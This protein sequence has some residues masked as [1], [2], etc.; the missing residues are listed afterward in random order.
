M[1]RLTDATRTQRRE[2]IAAAAMR[3]FAR[4]GFANTSMVD[5]IEAAGSSAG[6]VY[7]NFSSKSE[8]VR[9]AASNALGDLLDAVSQGLPSERTPASVLNHLLQSSSDRPH[10]RTLLQIWAEV[11]RDAALETIVRDAL[12]QLRAMVHAAV[13]P[14]CQSH[15]SRATPDPDA[16]ADALT[17]AIVTTT[18]G[19]L[20][21]IAIDEDVDPGELAT[22][23]VA[24]FEQLSN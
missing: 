1:P 12:R 20:V 9:F 2:A 24:I 21:R 15:P 13:L 17:D 8:L 22:R 7:S 18:Q 23:S 4:D 19:V 14:W 3:C 11:P 6:S 10:A 5:I 16:A